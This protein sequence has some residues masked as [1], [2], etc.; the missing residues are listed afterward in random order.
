[1]G[2]QHLYVGMG[3]QMQ[4]MKNLIKNIFNSL[5]LEIR[6]KSKYWRR[7]SLAEVLGHIAG[8]GFSPKT[9]IDVGVG[10]GTFS[11]RREEGKIDDQCALR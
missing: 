6:K 9:V 8:L 4:F 7:A 1:M 11:R 3:D 5:G 10:S 2:D